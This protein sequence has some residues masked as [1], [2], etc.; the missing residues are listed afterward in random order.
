ME[1][2]L[3]LEFGKD[4]TL[5]A[6]DWDALLLFERKVTHGDLVN[7]GTGKFSRKEDSCDKKVRPSAIL[8]PDLNL[9]VVTSRSSLRLC[10]R[11]T[12][13]PPLS[14]ELY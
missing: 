4:V 1:K 5:L 3:G 8:P 12:P 11:K 10:T 14:S 7:P 2:V 13:P 9:R 6:L